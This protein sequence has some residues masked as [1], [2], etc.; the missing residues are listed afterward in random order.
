MFPPRGVRQDIGEAFTAYKDY[1]DVSS[2]AHSQFMV[3]FMYA[4]GLG[5][6]RDQAKATLYYTFAALQGHKPAQMA[7]G[8]RYW[9]GIGVKEVGEMEWVWLTA[10]GLLD[11]AQ[12]LRVGGEKRLRCVHR[13]TA[14]RPDAAAD[15][16]TVV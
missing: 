2:D 14:R 16:D 5:G 7:M 15:P 4:T 1:L 6:E 8:Y 12:L 10:A 13:R 9:A 3:G 11:C